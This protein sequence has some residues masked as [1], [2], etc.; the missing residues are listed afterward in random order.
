MDRNPAQTF[1]ERMAQ[2]MTTDQLK[3]L[4]ELLGWMYSP[5]FVGFVDGTVCV[6]G[7][8]IDGMRLYKAPPDNTDLM[9][10]LMVDYEV[11]VVSYSGRWAS[12]AD[13]CDNW[14]QT[15]FSTPQLAILHAVLAKL[16]AQADEN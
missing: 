8:L 5:N 14:P 16:E 11:S 10:R 3:R 9:V 4:A 7:C 12:Y 2:A 1:E 6:S 15:K 13:H